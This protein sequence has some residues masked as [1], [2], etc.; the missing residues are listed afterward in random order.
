[1]NSRSFQRKVDRYDGQIIWIEGESWYELGNYLGGG[2][3][4]VVYEAVDLTADPTNRNVAIKILN[5]VGFKLM[6]SGPLQR[7]LVAV[8]GASISAESRGSVLAGP[9]LLLN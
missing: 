4:G 1:M 5:P 7:C 2:A 9:Q 3:A 8:K 6:P